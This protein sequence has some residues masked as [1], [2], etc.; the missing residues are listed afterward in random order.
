MLVFLFF[1]MGSRYPEDNE[2]YSDMPFK[3]RA[4]AGFETENNGPLAADQ[5]VGQAK[6]Q[7]VPGGRGCPLCIESAPG[8]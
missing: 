4:V 1:L 6:I 8:K 7:R 3:W 2:S 5:P